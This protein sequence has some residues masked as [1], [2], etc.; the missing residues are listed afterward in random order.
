[1][2]IKKEIHLK[3]KFQTQSQH[4]K[5]AVLYKNSNK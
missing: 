2:E 4:C 5:L 1:M 3:A